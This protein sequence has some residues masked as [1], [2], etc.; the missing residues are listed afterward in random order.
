MKS[1]AKSK[2]GVSYEFSAN[3]FKYAPAF[4]LDNQDLWP[5]ANDFGFNDSQYA[6]F[7]LALTSKLS[8]IQGYLFIFKND[9][10]YT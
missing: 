3:A 6:A 10:F 2:T 9:F 1:D 8:L 4:K 5:L 7:K